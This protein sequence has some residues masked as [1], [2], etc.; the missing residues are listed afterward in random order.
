M[1]ESVRM[2]V[3][4]FGN[5]RLSVHPVLSAGAM[6]QTDVAL[7]PSVTSALVFV[8][9]DERHLAVGI[10]IY[11]NDQTTCDLHAGEGVSRRVLSH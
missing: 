3:L 8:T 7:A 9:N 4:V 2:T 6:D 11:R 5:E 10:N 1:R